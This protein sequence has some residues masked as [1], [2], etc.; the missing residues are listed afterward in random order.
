MIDPLSGPV[1]TPAIVRVP[2]QQPLI[3][4]APYRI[5]IV[6]EAP[7]RD[8][9]LRGVPFVG[10]SGTSLE[11][12][13]SKAGINR[14]ACLVA[15]VCN[16]QPPGN[17]IA[18]FEWNGREFTEGLARL[19]ADLEAFKPNL[20]VLLGG[21]ALHV[22]RHP[23]VTPRVTRVKGEKVFKF[24]AAIGEWRGSMWTSHA[25]SPMPGVKCIATYHPAAALRQIE[26]SPLIR[27]DIMRAARE[28]AFAELRLPERI[29]DT[30]CDYMC[31]VDNLEMILA[32]KPAISIDIEGGL[33]TMSCISIATDRAYS[34]LVP[35]ARID[36]SSW[37]ET[38]DHEMH[39]WELLVDV[40]GDVSIPKILQNSLY[41]R[42]VL[43]YGYGIVVRGVVDDT[44]LKHWEL[45]CEMEKSLA[46][47]NSIYTDEPF[48]K[49]DRKT[50]SQ[51]VFFQYCCKDSATTF[52]ID[53][54][55]E[56]ILT[57]AQH[58]HYD[59]NMRVLDCCMYMQHRGLRYDGELA[60]KM[61][62]EVSTAIYEQQAALDDI[63]G[64]GLPKGTSREA[65][66]AK[67]REV[68][69][70]KK[71]PD[72]VRKAFVEAF[73]VNMR[74]LLGEGE[75]TV[76]ERGRLHTDCNIHCNTKSLKQYGALLYE[77]L[78]MPVQKNE[79]GRPT[80]D[81]EALLTLF[82]KNG[83]RAVEL[84]MNIN[85]L[86]TR[87]Q[88]LETP[89]DSDGRIR[90]S[91]N[92]GG[93]ET[94]RWKCYKSATGTGTN[95][96]TIP[97]KDLL[98]P[99]G[100]PLRKGMRQL[101]IADPGCYLFQ[102]DL[103]GSDLWTVA[104]NVAA[105]GCDTMLLDLKAGIKPH[106]VLCVIMTE[107]MSK[108][109]AMSREEIRD[110]CKKIDGDSWQYTMCKKVIHAGNYMMGAAKGVSTLFEESQ[111][112]VRVT[113]SQFKELQGLAQ[114]RYRV[115]LWHKR[116]RDYL[117]SQPYPPRMTS[118]S[119]QTRIFW[120]RPSEILAE[121]LANEPQQN[122]THATNLAADKL[123]RD[124][125]NRIYDTRA[126]HSN[127]H[128]S[129]DRAVGEARM[130]TIL[131]QY[132]YDKR[133]TTETD[134]SVQQVVLSTGEA[135]GI[136]QDGGVEGRWRPP[137]RLEPLHQVHD[138]LL[139]QA[140]IKD[141]S[142]CISAFAGYFANPM[143]IAGIEITI[144]YSGTFGTDWAM[145]KGYGLVGEFEG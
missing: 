9:V 101:M 49:S 48:Y 56:G 64:A 13:L 28:G 66:V 119:G 61:K 71:H 6:G 3:T 139:A 124:P 53:Q 127:D 97:K 17:R 27:L 109:M 44:M 111:G 118:A 144:P 52:E 128:K 113:E 12:H 46:F 116:T 26:F 39:I 50:D 137:F 98:K 14:Y 78:G 55:L 125:E 123:W 99:E 133:R 24:P 18:E 8:E 112:S 73:D 129:T 94:A 126:V 134:Q 1:T 77:T 74:T 95:M 43:Q 136:R 135:G 81:Y 19:R 105:C 32:Q 60:K 4:N 21:T 11:S 143:I 145:E 91:Y 88:Q 51:E 40:L 87:M 84:G 102:V 30:R 90:C 68:M 85:Q 104:A 20:C 58:T 82:Q 47:Q 76:A 62:K 29:L 41:D 57:P 80:L 69:C 23:D 33:G 70:H 103:S 107:G 35:F 54:K 121:A 38:E 142:W 42:F 22:F 10:A 89:V 37:W 86:R 131:P 15:N 67:L 117:K 132:V 25:L 34:I 114:K 93:T 59:L 122:T 120:G 63:A 31:L 96:T 7:G 100:H 108:V 115:D 65:Y 75:L 5:C 110:A 79:E 141:T 140:K 16:E 45:Y 36:G 72:R 106:K 83:H 138:S 130:D 92:V 2:N